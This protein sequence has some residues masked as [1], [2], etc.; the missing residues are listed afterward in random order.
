MLMHGEPKRVWREIG[1]DSAD[2]GI[3]SYSLAFGKIFFVLDVMASIEIASSNTG[4]FTEDLH[5]EW[6]HED[7]WTTDRSTLSGPGAR[8][9]WSAGLS[10]R[11][12]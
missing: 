6:S 11:E 2:I 5:L 3:F 10:K 1:Q 8:R 9:T 4:A 12:A 7:G